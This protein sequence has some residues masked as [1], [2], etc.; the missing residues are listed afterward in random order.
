[1]GRYQDGFMKAAID[2]AVLGWAE[3]HAQRGRDNR[4]RRPQALDLW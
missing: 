2:E 4:S 1:M 3:N